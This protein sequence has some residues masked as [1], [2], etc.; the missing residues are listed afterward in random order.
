MHLQWDRYSSP[1]TAQ[2]HGQVQGYRH[3]NLYGS[4]LGRYFTERAAVEL[5]PWRTTPLRWSGGPALA[6][7]RIGLCSALA[8]AGGHVGNA[9]F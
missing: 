8:S 5:R 1:T 6:G 4:L 2:H 3:Q 9:P 7:V